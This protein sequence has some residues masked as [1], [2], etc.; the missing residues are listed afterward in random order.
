[1][2]DG[3]GDQQWTGLSNTILRAQYK[4]KC[5]SPFKI[6]YKLQEGDSRALNQMWDLSKLGAFF[7]AQLY[8]Q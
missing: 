2:K 4:W 7:K 8:L 6:K 1:M 3:S 5:G